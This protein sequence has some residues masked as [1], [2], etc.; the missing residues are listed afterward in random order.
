MFLIVSKAS[1]LEDSMAMERGEFKLPEG[2]SM[3][4]FRREQENI[5]MWS[6][7]ILDVAKHLTTH[8]RQESYGHPLD[9]YTRTAALWSAILGTPVTPEKAI[10]C[11]VAVKISRECHQPARDNRVDM[12]GYVNCLDMLGP[13]RL[14]RGGAWVETDGIPL[15][16]PEP[17]LWAARLLEAI[18][19]LREEPVPD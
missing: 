2:Q 10:L 12:A 15:D 4:G 8:D 18:L 16:D 5:K 17:P 11:M 9:D 3:S 7:S 14:R 13:E 1:F 6:E 19:A